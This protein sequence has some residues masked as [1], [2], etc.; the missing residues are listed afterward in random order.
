MQVTKPGKGA[1]GTRAGGG[2]TSIKQMKQM[3][4]AVFC[5]FFLAVTARAAAPEK[6]S[7]F[8]LV[9]NWG[10]AI[11]FGKTKLRLLVQV[12][13]TPEGKLSGKI[14]IPDQGARD[15]PVSAMLSNYP[16]VRWEIDPFDNTAFNGKVSA[17]RNEIVGS[18]EEGP[19]GRPIAA[20]F[21]RLPASASEDV[22]RVYTFAPGEPRDIRGYWVGALEAERGT[23]NRVGLKIGRAADGTFGVL[24]DMLDRGALDISA[25]TVRWTNGS[26]KFEWQLFRADFEG[27]LDEKGD[28]LTGTW[29]QRGKGTPASFDRLSQ[30]A[31]TLP[32]NVSFTPDKDTSDDLRGDWKGVLEIPDN[33]KMRIVL[34][35]GRTPEGVF[36]GTLSSPDQGGGDIPM[37]SGSYTNHQARLEW[38][39]I[40]GVYK[41][42]LTNQGAVLEGT[43]EQMGPGLKLRL[44]RTAAQ[45]ATSTK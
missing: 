38:K 31:K 2:L 39:A 17:D 28:R 26:A 4:L 43:W 27:K 19:G 25:S 16:W 5:L 29:Q 21:K 40:N 35:I 22:P 34:H 1:S 15:I 8:D 10:S 33:A 42:T 9:G 3:K 6:G 32:D 45:A 7:V 18:F 30:P 36:A 11:E 12:T 13:K 14:A 44:E 37:S 41:G 23:T 20:T 24:L